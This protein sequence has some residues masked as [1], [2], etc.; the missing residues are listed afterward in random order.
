MDRE[1]GKTS[2]SYSPTPGIEA[3]REVGNEEEEEKRG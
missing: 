2:P 1:Q 3:L